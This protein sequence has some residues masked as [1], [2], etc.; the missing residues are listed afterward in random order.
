MKRKI[1]K[2]KY[3]INHTC[4]IYFLGERYSKFTGYRVCYNP[5]YCFI[6]DV[7]FSAAVIRDIKSDSIILY[8]D[9]FLLLPEEVRLDVLMHEVGHIENGYCSEDITHTDKEIAADIFAA[10]KRGIKDYIKRRYKL[11]EIYQLISDVVGTKIDDTNFE[12]EEKI[13]GILNKLVTEDEREELSY[14]N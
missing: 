2:T 5:E 9:F 3:A 10:K 8:D 14:G 12:Y 4:R 13:I 1:R 7:M 11:M 6:N